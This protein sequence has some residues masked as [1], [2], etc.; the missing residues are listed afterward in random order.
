MS[1]YM[2]LYFEL[3]NTRCCIAKWEKW[4]FVAAKGFGMKNLFEKGEGE[5]TAGDKKAATRTNR[6]N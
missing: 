4:A 6:W 3:S 2:I 1:K 5:G